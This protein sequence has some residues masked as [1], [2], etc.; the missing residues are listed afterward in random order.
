MGLLSDVRARI[1]ALHVKI[2]LQELSRKSGVPYS[3]IRYIYLGKTKAPRID[4]LTKLKE[5]FDARR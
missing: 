2:S 5:F 3:T 4:T 1:A